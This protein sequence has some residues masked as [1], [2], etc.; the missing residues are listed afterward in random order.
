MSKSCFG[1]A[2]ADDIV[3]CDEP[4]AAGEA[5]APLIPAVSSSGPTSSPRAHGIPCLAGDG[6]RRR[7]RYLIWTLI[8]RCFALPA[9]LRYRAT[10]RMLNQFTAQPPPKPRKLP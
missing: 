9:H 2:A 7:A 10:T 3:G 6:I 4:C 8:V 5:A 1:A